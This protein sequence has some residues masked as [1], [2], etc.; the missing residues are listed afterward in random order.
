MDGIGNP[1]QDGAEGRHPDVLDGCEVEE[2]V[3]FLDARLA[4]FVV[5]I[6]ENGRHYVLY[7][8]KSPFKN[9]GIKVRIGHS[10]KVAPVAG[11]RRAGL[12]LPPAL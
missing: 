4:R 10:V 11:V 3:H 2:R 6:P 12:P 7:F 1:Q 8:G 9:D 5:K